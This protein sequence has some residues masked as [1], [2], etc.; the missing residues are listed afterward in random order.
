MFIGDIYYSQFCPIVNMDYGSWP[1]KQET[2]KKRH[3]GPSH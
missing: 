3:K 1:K 2:E